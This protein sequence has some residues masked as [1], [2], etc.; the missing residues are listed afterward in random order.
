MKSYSASGNR[1]PNCPLC[2]RVSLSRGACNRFPLP[3]LWPERNRL[4]D[5][6]PSLAKLSHDAE[7]DRYFRTIRKDHAFRIR[8]D[9]AGIYSIT[10][11]RCADISYRSTRPVANETFPISLF[12][13]RNLISTFVMEYS[14]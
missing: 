3:P 4:L 6:A 11:R 7:A 12:E 14:F 9:A 10:G 5:G 13:R 2:P 1:A 8:K